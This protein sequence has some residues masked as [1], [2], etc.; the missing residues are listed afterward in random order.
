MRT[1]SWRN[2]PP[3]AASP[4]R[5]MAGR[6]M[7]VPRLGRE[8]L[9]R[10]RRPGRARMAV[11]AQWRAWRGGCRCWRGGRWRGWC[12]GG[13][14]GVWRGR[15]GGRG[16]GGGGGGRPGLDPADVGW[17]LATSRSTFEHRAV[18]TGAGGEELVAGLGAV[19]A[20]V[21]GAGGLGGG[22]VFSGQGAQRAGMGAELYA[23]SPVFAAA[24]DE[25]CGLLE[26]RLGVPVADVVLGRGGDG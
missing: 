11:V 21:P 4:G 6:R 20:G 17:S 12:R 2:P 1:S 16:G 8:V 19:A 22:F 9:V 3:P 7:T 14:R 13:R 23:A 25:A 15:R 5:G 26:A 24:F 10:R 18:V